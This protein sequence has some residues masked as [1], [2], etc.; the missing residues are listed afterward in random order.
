MKKY[1]FLIFLFIICLIL[2]LN[3]NSTEK[4]ISYEEKSKEYIISIN[5][6]FNEGINSNKLNELFNKYDKEYYIRKIS[7]NDEVL[8]ISCKELSE[9]IKETFNLKDNDFYNKYIVNGFKINN[10]NLIAYKDEI[11]PFLNNEKISYTID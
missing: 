5:L 9:C 4:V 8:E 11:I 7:L 1:F 2:N 3:D 6:D 10:L